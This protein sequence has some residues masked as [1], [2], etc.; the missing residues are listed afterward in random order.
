M[1]E[2][3]RCWEDRAAGPTESR[4]CILCLTAGACRTIIAQFERRFAAAPGDLVSVDASGCQR[5][6]HHQRRHFIY[7]RV[8]DRAGCVL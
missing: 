5:Q 2:C 4:S 6:T 3:K 8:F 1:C 7:V